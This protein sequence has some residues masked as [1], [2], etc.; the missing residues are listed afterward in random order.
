[1]ARKL[2]ITIEDTVYEVLVEDITAKGEEKGR[3]SVRKVTL[4]DANLQ[5]ENEEVRISTH[6]GVIVDI[7]VSEGQ[8]VEKGDELMTIEAM[9]IVNTIT[10]H[11]K[12]KVTNIEVLVNQTV[13]EGQKLL[14]I[15]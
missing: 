12:G 6:N 13:Y 15:Q 11:R 10:S 7:M 5:N 9:K 4:P 14:T 2:K 8:M 3:T 1:M